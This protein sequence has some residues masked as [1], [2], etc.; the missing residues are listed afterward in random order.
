MKNIR[1]KEKKLKQKESGIT[2]EKEICPECGAKVTNVKQHIKFKHEIDKQKCPQCDK[3]FK[4]FL[5]L[6]NHMKFH[7]KVPCPHC[8][9]PRDINEWV[10]KE[11]KFSLSFANTSHTS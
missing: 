10:A 8:G 4:N 9:K 7:E 11:S 1:K 6:Q 3:E 5:H 2:K